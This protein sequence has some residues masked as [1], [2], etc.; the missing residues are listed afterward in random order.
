MPVFFWIKAFIITQIT[1]LLILYKLPICLYYFQLNL[2]PLLIYRNFLCTGLKQII[3]TV[4][5]RWPTKIL[6]VH[7]ITPVVWHDEQTDQILKTT[8]LVDE[9]LQTEVIKKI[10]SQDSVTVCS[11]TFLGCPS[12]TVTWSITSFLKS[13]KY[14]LQD[15]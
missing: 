12:G 15:W 1:C 5:S 10:K 6:L 9:D 14:Y 11:I 7:E 8:T 4:I 13:G 3:M 2:S